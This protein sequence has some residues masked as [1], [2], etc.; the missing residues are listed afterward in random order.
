MTADAVK[1]IYGAPTT[2][3]DTLITYTDG[4]ATLSFVL[5]DTRV[6]SIEYIPA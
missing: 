6:I 3:S 2:E 1:G 4:N 5:K